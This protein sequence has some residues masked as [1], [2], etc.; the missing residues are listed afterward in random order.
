MVMMVYVLSKKDK[1]IKI[2]VTCIV[3]SLSIQVILALLG[4]QRQIINS[5]RGV[6]F[7]NN[8]N[9]LGYYSLSMLTIITILL[10]KIQLKKLTIFIII[11][12][13]AY[14]VLFSGS[15]AALAGILLL[16][17]INM[18]QLGFKLNFG[19]LILIL[20]FF[21]CLPFV[22]NSDFVQKKIDLIES[23]NNRNTHSNISEAQIRGYDRIYLNPQYIF[24]G[25]GEGK[26][27][28][29]TSH[30]E[31]EIHSAFGTM[32]FSYGILGLLLLLSIINESIKK[33][34]LLGAVILLPILVYNITHNGLRNSLLW[35]ILG[36]MSVV[37]LNK[38]KNDKKN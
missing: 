37:L 1:Y 32:L 36:A 29:F 13:S 21:I 35:G 12:L 28:R 11:G 15:R 18:Y 3:V 19:Y 5:S 33:N 10:Q 38:E 23:R 30:H 14:L 20:T 17:G 2:I 31:L 4:I 24:L 7:F 6:I 25:A 9:Q 26:N 22:I 27:D 16:G 8:P 34:R